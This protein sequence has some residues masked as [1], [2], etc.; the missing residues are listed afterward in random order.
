MAQ[1]NTGL[2]QTVYAILRSTR[3]AAADDD[4]RGPDD[5]PRDVLVRY[6]G[7]T[8]AEDFIGGADLEFDRGDGAREVIILKMTCSSA[9]VAA[10]GP[11]T[12]EMLV[13]YP[14]TTAHSIEVAPEEMKVSPRHSVQQ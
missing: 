6:G 3:G 12:G 13:A 5:A 2:S 11:D 10:P 14:Q 8:N 4:S 7:V 1:E 9:I